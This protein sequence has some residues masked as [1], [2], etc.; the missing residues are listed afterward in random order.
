MESSKFMSGMLRMST[1]STT[2]SAELLCRALFFRKD[3]PKFFPPKTSISNPVSF[4]PRIKASIA[5]SL[6]TI[7]SRDKEMAEEI[8][9]MK[10]AVPEPNASQ[11]NFELIAEK[12]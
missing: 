12:D 9:S 10:P 8:L 5:P 7:L 2:K 11:R 1:D 3:L 6:S 4:I